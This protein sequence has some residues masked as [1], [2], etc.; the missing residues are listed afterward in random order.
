MEKSHE[1][2]IINFKLDRQPTTEESAAFEIVKKLQD[3]GFETYIAGGAVRDLYL[4]RP[5]HDID[6][7]TAAEP[8]KI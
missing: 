8:E 4:R 3:K 7:A 6:I 5:V 1:P 2:Q